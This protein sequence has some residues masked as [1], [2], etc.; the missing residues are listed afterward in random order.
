MLGYS[1]SDIELAR[2]VDA[3]LTSKGC[4]V[5]RDERDRSNDSIVDATLKG[6]PETDVFVCLVSAAY[7]KSLNC[8]AEFEFA[9]MNNKTLVL[10][11]VDPTIDFHRTWIAPDLAGVHYTVTLTD[12]EGPMEELYAKEI[13]ARASVPQASPWF[14]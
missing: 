10:V 7:V 4:A 9:K 2:R 8:R 5:R 3:F 12:F 13:C 6:F 14:S 11:V 1:W